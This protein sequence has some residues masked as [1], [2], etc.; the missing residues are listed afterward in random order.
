[1]CSSLPRTGGIRTRLRK[2]NTAP[3]ARPLQTAPLDGKVTAT[4]NTG[5]TCAPIASMVNYAACITCEINIDFALSR[6][7]DRL[8]RRMNPDIKSAQLLPLGAFAGQ[9]LASLAPAGSP[10]VGLRIAPPARS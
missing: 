5:Q 3:A 2:I 9:P 4:E 8:R 6:P 7:R 1:S 10:T